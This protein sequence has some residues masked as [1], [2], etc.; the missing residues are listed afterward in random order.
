MYIY[1]YTYT[2]EKPP[3]NIFRHLYRIAGE[4]VLDGELLGGVSFKDGKPS[5]TNKRCKHGNFI[6]L[7]VS[8][9]L[10]NTSQLG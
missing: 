4:K 8:T 2:I 9:H 5:R 7:V 3:F 6:W 1:I 10:K